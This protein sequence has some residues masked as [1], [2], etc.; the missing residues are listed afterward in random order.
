MARSLMTA[1]SKR[2]RAILLCAFA[3]LLCQPFGALAG[4]AADIAG[5]WT[6]TL[7]TGPTSLH[8]E[9]H[10]TA[11][12]SG[13]LSVTF[14]S[15]DQNAFGLPGSD[16]ALNGS[17]FGFKIPVVSGSYTGTISG[18][19]KKIDGNWT[20][21]GTLPLVFT[22]VATVAHKPA[23]LAGDWYAPMLIGGD[24]ARLVLHIKVDAA[25]KISLTFDNIDQKVFGLPGSDVAFNGATLTFMVPSVVA[26]FGGTLSDDGS[27]INGNWTE[28]AVFPV[29]F[30]RY[31]G[32]P[33]PSAVPTPKSAAARP[34][35]A[36]NDLKPILDAEMAP[37]L[38][39]GLL[40]SA[41]GGGG[42]VIG[43]LDHGRRRVFAYGAAKPDSI[44]EIGSIT[45]TFTGLILAQMVVQK[46]VTLDEPIRMLLPK[47]FVAKPDG[48]EITLLDLA[49]QHSGLP[50]MPDNFKPKN[51]ENPYADYD[52][53]RL[54]DFMSTQGVAKPAQTYFH[55]SNLGFALLGYGLAQRAGTSYA[56][57]LSDEVLT[58]LKMT[59]T[60]LTLSPPQKARLIQG[61]DDHFDPAVP[62]D[63]NAFDSAGGLKSTAD[64][65]LTYLDANMHPEKYVAG[66]KS[67]SAASTLPTA[68]AID[69]QLRANITPNGDK[70]IA[71]TWWF[72]RKTGSYSHGGGTGGYTSMAGFNPQRDVAVVALYNRENTDINAPPFAQ[73]IAENVSDLLK[74]EP[75]IPIDY[76]S[77]DERVLLI[78]A[79]FSNSS[80]AGAYHC[81][82]TAFTLP[83]NTKDPFKP[84]AT[85]DIHIVADGNGKFT[86][87]TWSHHIDAYKLTCNLQMV[88]GDYSVT[89]NGTGKEHFSWK[90]D[91]EKSPRGCFQFFSPARPPVTS[92]PHLIVTDTSGKTIY[93]TSINPFA[94]LSAVCQRETAQTADRQ[95][96]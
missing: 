86:E 60:A 96:P 81:A 5:E 53:S 23:E 70:K 77:D 34:P 80:I 75:A 71:L 37:V 28:D 41:S 59:D 68:M 83:A 2:N 67:G 90:L 54:R 8:L 21:N 87:G 55:Y 16:V 19:G 52:E 63:L 13:K 7:Q 22:R 44:F 46:K 4:K 26:S 32:G 9:L 57:L 35:V 64:D 85:G 61:H 91:L 76:L 89:S 66:A 51:P 69:H 79:T 30:K 65:M 17:T 38:E 62:W 45:K 36:L 6:G 95:V 15:L 88:S 50:R 3:F 10:V 78:P 1:I 56:Q 31:S 40:S 11:D 14:D 29:K 39:H 20:Q 18:D 58:P 27:S 43:V 42:L 92:E 93:S 48:S 74:G 24:S 25:G 12:S 94:V 84:T 47:D 33:T 49:T 72:D 73:R 82:L